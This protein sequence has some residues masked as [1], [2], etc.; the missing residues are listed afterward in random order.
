MLP[1]MPL[2]KGPPP[3]L[4]DHTEFE[5]CLIGSVRLSQRKDFFNIALM[6]LGHQGSHPCEEYQ[7]T[8]SIRAIETKILPAFAEATDEERSNVS[9]IFI[10]SICF[11]YRGPLTL[12]HF[13]FKFAA[14]PIFSATVCASA[15][16]KETLLHISILENLPGLVGISELCDGQHGE[17]LGVL[18]S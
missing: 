6:P 17:S 13:A 15:T 12:H 2:K 10:E 9:T 1:A 8:K 14:C 4:L 3:H 11:K 16:H 18:L 5:L 7:S